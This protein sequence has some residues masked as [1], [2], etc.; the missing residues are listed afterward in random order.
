MDRLITVTVRHQTRMPPDKGDP[1]TTHGKGKHKGNDSPV[2]V[3]VNA[4]LQACAGSDCPTDNDDQLD[5]Y[6]PACRLAG[7]S[8]PEFGEHHGNLCAVLENRNP[9]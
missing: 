5:H 3:A 4:G 7:T 9:F 2:P 1:V 6:C 8:D